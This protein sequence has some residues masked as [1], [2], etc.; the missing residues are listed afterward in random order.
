MLRELARVPGRAARGGAPGAA[1]R[2]TKRR[3]SALAALEEMRMLS[4]LETEKSKLIQIVLVGQPDLREKLAAPELEQ[5]RQRVTVSYHLR[6]LDADETAAYINHRLR[7]RRD[8]RAAGVPARRD[9]S[10]PRTQRRRAAHDQRDLRRDPAVRLRRGTRATID[11]ALVDEVIDG[12]RS[13]RRAAARRRRGAPPDSSPAVA[14]LRPATR[15]RRVGRSRGARRAPRRAAASR[16]AQRQLRARRDRAAAALHE[17][18]RA[19]SSA[20][21]LAEQRAAAADDTPADRRQPHAAPRW[22]AAAHPP[23]P[24]RHGRGRRRSAGLRRAAAPFDRV[25]GRRA[26]RILGK[27]VRRALVGDPRPRST[28]VS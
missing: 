14:P 27:R 13:D 25:R 19:P 1:G 8:R 6:P 15:Q 11:L 22:R 16:G 7:A 12:A 17:R 20:R 3:T 5:L 9:R 2:S 21:V 18:E 26:A 28:N 24:R 10:G 4:N 23:P